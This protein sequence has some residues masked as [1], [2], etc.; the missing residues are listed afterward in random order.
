MP[1]PIP[2]QMFSAIPACHDHH[3]IAQ[4][5]PFEHPYDHHPRPAFPIIILERPVIEQHRPC[6]MRGLGEFLVALEGFEKGEGLIFR[7]RRSRR[8]LRIL[9]RGQ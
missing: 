9:S 4:A 1:K 3:V 7:S 2:A 5:C 8:R 6:V